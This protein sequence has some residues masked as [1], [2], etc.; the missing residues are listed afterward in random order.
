M[1]LK[2]ISSASDQDNTTQVLRSPAGHLNARI[3]LRTSMSSVIVLPPEGLGVELLAAGLVYGSLVRAG[4][5]I[6]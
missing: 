3:G 5:L 1:Q 6:T 4:V 2:E